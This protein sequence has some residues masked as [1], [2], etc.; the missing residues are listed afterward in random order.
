[1]AIMRYIPYA[2][3]VLLLVIIGF[4][5]FISGIDN[6]SNASAAYNNALASCRAYPN[7]STQQIAETSRVIVYLPKALYPNQAGLLSFRTISGTAKADWISNAGLPGQSYGASS[8]CF[9]Y[10]YE[11]DGAGEVDLTA[12]SSIASAPN[13]SVRFLVASQGTTTSNIHLSGAETG[14]ISGVVLLGPTCP[15]EHVPPDSQCAP[16]PYQTTITISDSMSKALITKIYS[17]AD[18]TFNVSL[19][20][21]S[22]TLMAGGTSYY[23]RCSPAQVSVSANKA[24][25]VTINCDTGIR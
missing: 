15:V 5:V 14:E 24:A 7:G 16:K 25:Q 10:D 11:F 4:L 20:P 1:M 13:Y 9:A 6:R 12:T 21:G 23:P 22:Y 2:L 8:N 17:G 19:V 18:G 3:G